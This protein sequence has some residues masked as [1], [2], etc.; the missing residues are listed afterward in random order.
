M[1]HYYSNPNFTNLKHG[2]FLW[3]YL[4]S[5]NVIDGKQQ[6]VII[7]SCDIIVLPHSFCTMHITFEGL[8]YE[9]NNLERLT[10]IVGCWLDSLPAPNF[11][12]VSKKHYWDALYIKY[13]A[14][15]RKYPWWKAIRTKQKLPWMGPDRE[16]YLNVLISFYKTFRILVNY[17]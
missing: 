7:I 17:Y 6:F 4:S 14:F 10:A 9:Q 11:I 2:L 5:I 16:I 13:I 8:G 3:I 1:S 15:L 12:A